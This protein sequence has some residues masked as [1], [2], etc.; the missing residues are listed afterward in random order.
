MEERARQRLRSFIDDEAEST[1]ND[2]EEG[3]GRHLRIPRP[4][5]LSDL[6]REQESDNDDIYASD[7]QPDES[8]HFDYDT[9]TDDSFIEHETS[10]SD[11]RPSRLLLPPA[12]VGRDSQHDEIDAGEIMAPSSQD[13][14][15]GLTQGLLSLQLS[16][17]AIVDRLDNPPDHTDPGEGRRNITDVRRVRRRGWFITCFPPENTEITIQ[18]AISREI[19]NIESYCISRDLGPNSLRV[20]FHVAIYFKTPQ[21]FTKLDSMFPRRANIQFIYKKYWQAR[22]YVIG[23]AR[24][25]E[26][27]II[28]A[29][30]NPQEAPRFDSKTRNKI[31]RREIFFSLLKKN[32]TEKNLQEMMKKYPETCIQFEKEGLRWLQLVKPTVLR[33]DED[34]THFRKPL[35]VVYFYGITGSMKTTWAKRLARRF[36]TYC[37]TSIS[38]SGQLVS[39]EQGCECLLLNDINPDFIQKNQ[40]L[41]LTLTEHGPTKIDVK[42][43]FCDYDTKIVIFTR[44]EHPEEWRNR[45][46]LRANNFVDQFLRRITHL[47]H[48]ERVAKPDKPFASLDNYQDWDFRAT[49]VKNRRPFSI[50]DIL[51]YV[52][53]E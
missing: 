19:S 3:L 6:L 20:H 10:D 49:D 16:E 12:P 35:C 5:S 43:G 48:C 39:F 30:Y 13:S 31:S 44:T 8:Q 7:S 41:I 51:D 47:I 53:S 42:G 29:D 33:D 52:N 38:P 17:N 11:T 23:K 22:A 18:E 50:K 14:T 15:V 1:S 28:M 45:E 24:H 36:D 2:S 37:S 32:P 4:P 27:K 25:G 40:Q 26:N 46:E 9:T 34:D 21:L